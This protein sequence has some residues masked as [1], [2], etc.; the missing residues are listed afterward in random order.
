MPPTFDPA[1]AERLQREYG[2]NLEEIP[3]LLGVLTPAE[4]ARFDALFAPR[5][6]REDHPKYNFLK[7]LRT[8]V[9]TVDEARAGEVRAWPFDYVDEKGRSWNEYWEVWDRAL[10]TEELLFVDKVRRVMASNVVVAWDL[11]IL[12][13]GQDPRWPMLMK[14]DRNRLVLI[15]S[16]KLDGETGSEAFVYKLQQMCKHFEENG[17]R[18]YWKDFPKAKWSAQKALFTNGSRV[19]AVAQGADQIRGPGITHAHIEEAAAMDEIEASVTTAIPTLAGGGHL[20]MVATPD[21]GANFLIRLREG[22]LGAKR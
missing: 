12:A 8:C 11:W 4:K 2:I 13:G 20:T 6:R 10:H 16:K 21:A 9:F 3:E 19:Q 18:K 15:Q 5:P 7:F 1:I 14:S 17:G 22:R